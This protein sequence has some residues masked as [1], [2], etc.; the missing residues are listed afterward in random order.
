MII[1]LIGYPEEE[2]QEILED[3]KEKESLKK[4]GKN[5]K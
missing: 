2:D 4:L 1:E 3:F 5:A